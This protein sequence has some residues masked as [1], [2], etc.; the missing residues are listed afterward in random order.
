MTPTEVQNVMEYTDRQFPKS[1]WSDENRTLFMERLLKVNVTLEQAHAVVAEY[2]VSV[3]WRS[4][5][6]RDL[7]DRMHSARGA[8]AREQRLPE[9][10]QPG[11]PPITGYNRE[12]VARY[13]ANPNDP[14]F[15]RLA[16]EGMSVF[17]ATRGMRGTA[18][19][20][21]EVEAAGA[22]P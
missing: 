3:R 4:P 7:I 22:N 14:V 9:V 19:D 13:D 15:A 16:K 10:S 20:A 18:K 8:V 1:E 21:A 11:V 12:L 17:V 5:N 6:M 2:R